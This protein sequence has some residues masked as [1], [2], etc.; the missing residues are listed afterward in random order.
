[1]SKLNTRT[2]DSQSMMVHNRLLLDC[3]QS[4]QSNQLVLP[5]I[6]DVSFKIRRAINDEKANS[7]KIARVVQI[8]PSI[9]A[10]L[11]KIANSPLYRGRKPIESCPEAL[12]RLGLNAVQNIVTA[13]SMKSVFNAKSRL[14][15]HEMVELWRH[16]SYVA[17]ISAVIAHKI[18]GFDPDRAMLAGLIHDI[19]VVPVLVHAENHLD[20]IS[21]SEDI[22]DAIGQLR[23]DI[24]VEIIR[25]WGF[26]DDFEEVVINAENWYRNNNAPLD[27]SDIVMIAQLHSYIGT[28]DIKKTPKLNE[29]PI[30]KKWAEHLKAS[31]SIAIL[32][33]A[34]DEIDYIWGSLN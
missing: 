33:K 18:P 3:Y 24:G 28:D 23:V 1:M 29:L 12:T 34:R 13:F 26:P 8:D 16:S 6:P 31:D 22:A 19:G 2:R 9:T 25:Q 17:A 32:D 27:Y 15:H 14:I 30:Y 4:L 20:I 11:I 21:R 10:R 5:T 7:S